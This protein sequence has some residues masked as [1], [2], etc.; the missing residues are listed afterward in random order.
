MNRFRYIDKKILCSYDLSEDF[1]QK[2]GVTVNDVIPLRKVFVLFT[3][4]GKKILK[5]TESSEERVNFI[6][7][8]LSIIRE[9]DPYVLEYC[10]N[11]NNE[12]ITEWKNKKYILLDMIDGREATFTNPIEVELCSKALANLHEASKGIV[13]KVDKRELEY[14]SGKNLIHE[15]LKELCF[16][17]EM[18]RIV[19][20]YKFK[21]EFD[22]LF[23]Y[24]ISKAKNDLEKCINCLIKSPY[25]NLYNNEDNK[26]ICHRD[27]AHHNFIIYD[28]NINLID[29]DYCKIDIR[30]NDIYNFMVKVIKNTAYNKE[31]VISIIKNYSSISNITQEEQEVLYSLLIYPRDFINITKDYYLKQKSWDEEVFISRFKE[32]IELDEF[33]S[34]LLRKL[35]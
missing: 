18:E 24:N 17:I 33:R 30:V 19:G 10:K 28:E 31:S 26:V 1:F 25:I 34:E 21:N 2:L 16:I 6:N 12:I 13:R 4:K 35:N 14:N 20:R 22:T 9:K 32:K 3:N 27:L 29:F 7:K 8:A 5:S 15:F 11:C 23:L